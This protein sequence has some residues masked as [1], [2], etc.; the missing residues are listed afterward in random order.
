MKNG[1]SVL[2]VARP[3]RMRD[4]LRALLRAIPNLEEI[5]QA[6]DSTAAL[7]VVDNHPP[8]LML[9]DWNLPDDQGQTVLAHTRSCTQIPCIVLADNTRQQQLAE[10]GGA[11]AVLIAGFPANKLFTEVERLLDEQ[12]AARL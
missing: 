4:G 7:A 10:A 9:L 6:D 1:A 8:A 12:G 2:I 3:N 11:D 5:G